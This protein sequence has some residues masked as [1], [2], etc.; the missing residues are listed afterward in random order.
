M[1]S[2]WERG[3]KRPDGRSLKRLNLAKARCLMAMAQ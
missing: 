2:K 3:E 1:V